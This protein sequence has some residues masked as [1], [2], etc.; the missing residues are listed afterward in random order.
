MSSVLV[1]PKLLLA[2]SLTCSL[3]LPLPNDAGNVRRFEV[4]HEEALE[5]QRAALADPNFPKTQA[6]WRFIGRDNVASMIALRE[7]HDAPEKAKGAEDGDGGDKEGSK[8]RLLVV[9]NCHLHWNPRHADVKAIQCAMMME[10]LST[11]V[12]P[13]TSADTTGLSSCGPAIDEESNDIGAMQ[14]MKAKR[15]DLS[16]AAVIICGDFNSQPHSRVIQLLHHGHVD[17]SL[18]GGNDDGGGGVEKDKEECELDTREWCELLKRR[19]VYDTW[20]SKRGWKLEHT[21]GR[22]RSAYPIPPPPPPSPAGEGRARGAEEKACAMESASEKELA[23]E[24][25]DE[26]P[27][28]TNR[29]PRFCGTLD[30]IWYTAASLVSHTSGSALLS[31]GNM[32]DRGRVEK[33]GATAGA[34]ERWRLDR[35]SVLGAVRPDTYWYDER[36]AGNERWLPTVHYPSE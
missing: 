8:G 25:R 24:L 4:V 14:T 34:A 10:W 11:L 23:K 3:A 19:M 9:A 16:Q 22:L 15:P 21:L 28:F 32:D 31:D 12:A 18:D 7:L 27:R 17:L 20:L 36:E 6:A 35:V 33:G 29:T 1:L 13:L 30:Y 5:F 2:C 26:L